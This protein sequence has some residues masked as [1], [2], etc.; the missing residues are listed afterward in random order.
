MRAQKHSVWATVCVTLL[1]G[2]CAGPLSAGD[3]PAES[4]TVT[5][6]PSSAAVRDNTP[7]PDQAASNTSAPPSLDLLPAWTLP[8]KCLSPKSVQGILGTGTLTVDIATETPVCDYSEGSSQYWYW[9]DN[10]MLLLDP[11]QRDTSSAAFVDAPDLGRDALRIL[12]RV[13]GGR[14]AHSCQLKVRLDRDHGVDAAGYPLTTLNVLI[15]DKGVASEDLCAPAQKLLNA[16][17]QR[18]AFASGFSPSTPSTTP[19]INTSNWP[20]PVDCSEGT[21]PPEHIA[22]CKVAGK[23]QVQVFRACEAAALGT[24]WDNSHRPKLGVQNRNLAADVETC[25]RGSGLEKNSLDSNVLG[26]LNKKG[27]LQYIL[28]LGYD[29]GVESSYSHAFDVTDSGAGFVAFNEDDIINKMVSFYQEL[30]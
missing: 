10:E 30:S 29:P 23:T 4:A 24:L 25:V 7:L 18:T 6:G 3:G 21:P 26:Y 20:R 12:G 15:S 9:A 2:G 5:S 1:L 11:K 13:A 14:K 19:T 16:V 17:S 8:T 22:Y 28:V 27:N